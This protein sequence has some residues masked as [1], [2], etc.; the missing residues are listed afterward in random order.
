MPDQNDAEKYETPRPGKGDT[1]HALARAGISSVPYVGGAGVELFAALVT[2]PLERRRLEWMEEVGEG[3]RSLE[4]ETDLS[5]EDLQDNDAF[6][7]A[8]MSASQAAIRTSQA[9]KREAL[10]NAVLNAAL[11]SA[12]EESLQQFFV[13]LVDEF[14]VW[15]LLILKLF[16]GPVQWAEEHN[17]DFPSM[18]TS[19]L[20]NTLESAFPKLKG[21]RSFYDQVW[22]DLNRRGLVSTDS[23]HGMMTA[24]GALSKRTSDI[25]DAFLHFI[26]KPES[27]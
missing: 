7:D 10:R 18:H 11:P 17:H 2:P 22:S 25:G 3:L 14:T 9:E 24:S 12:P 5:L 20:S 8:V 4:A 6:I 23:L 1:L 27:R 15:H 19:S 13:A 16:Q 21:R 26:E